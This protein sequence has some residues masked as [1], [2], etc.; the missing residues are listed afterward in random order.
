M[1]FLNFGQFIF[2][3]VWEGLLA[4]KYTEVSSFINTGE[5]SEHGMYKKK[6]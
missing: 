4:R 2:P 1:A 3:F 5:W 6:I